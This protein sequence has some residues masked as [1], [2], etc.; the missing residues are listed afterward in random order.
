MYDRPF[1]INFIIQDTEG[2]QTYTNILYSRGAPKKVDANST[3]VV[4]NESTH[5][6][7]D[8]SGGE[9]EIENAKELE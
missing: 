7:G 3:G 2:C 5:E 6:A 9:K 1:D 8:G 4:R